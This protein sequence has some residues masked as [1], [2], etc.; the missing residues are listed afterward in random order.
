MSHG[1]SRVGIYGRKLGMTRVFAGKTLAHPVTLLKVI[2]NRVLRVKTPESD[3]YWGLEVSYGDKVKAKQRSKAVRGHFLSLGAELSEGHAE[4][5]LGKEE[6]DSFKAGD[7]LGVE[8]FE[9]GEKV[10]VRATSKGRGFAGVIKRWNFSR[11]RESHGTSLSHRTPGSTGQRQDPGRV[12]K[13][14]KMPGH[15]GDE[16][17]SIQNL[18]VLVADQENSL[19][20]LRGA[21]PGAPGALVRVV[22]N[23]KGR[24]PVDPTKLEIDPPKPEESEGTSAE[25]S[26]EAKPG[27]QETSSEEKPKEAKAAPAG[28]AVE[29]KPSQEEALSGEKAEEAK[30]ASV[31]KAAKSKPE[32]KEAA[33]EG[34]P[35]ESEKASA[36]KAAESKP[37]QEK[38]SSGEKP[39][40]KE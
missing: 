11:G 1:I 13:G 2:P 38:A 23:Q 33:S 12:F 21:V 15:L 25:K 4:F 5:R 6:A 16:K 39:E 29:S 7:L 8:R 35:E 32:Q 9:V 34:K 24:G 18:V 27:Q 40:S 30:N 28:E 19:L 17:V 36:G 3:G 14:K 20:A 37:S 22:P 10:D 26:A 31:E